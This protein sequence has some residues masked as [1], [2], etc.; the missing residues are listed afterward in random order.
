M[1]TVRI[2]KPIFYLFVFLLLFFLFFGVFAFFLWN[3]SRQTWDI[4]LQHTFIYTC[5]LTHMTG[6]SGDTIWVP[7]DQ[8]PINQCSPDKKPQFVQVSVWENVQE[9]HPP[10]LHCCLWLQESLPGCQ[11]QTG[12]CHSCVW[13]RS[14]KVSEPLSSW[15]TAH[16]HQTGQRQVHLWWEMYPG[17]INNHMTKRAYFSSRKQ[18]NKNS[19]VQ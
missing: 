13:R 6:S 2:W 14:Q 8:R 19:K 1:K 10:D 12:Q 7:T 3:S 4:K 5:N 17:R 9:S 15:P 11:D 18:T 16:H